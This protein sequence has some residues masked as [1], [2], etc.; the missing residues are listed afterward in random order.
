[1]QAV[2]P[3]SKTG[4][5]PFEK[6]LRIVRENAVLLGTERAPLAACVGR[7]LREDAASDMAMP[8]FDKSAMDG[9]ACRRPDLPGPLEV[10]ETIPAGQRPSR[11]VGKGQ[12][13]KIMTGAM[14]PKGADCVI[15]V[16][17]TET[18]PDGRVRRR[19]R[20]GADHGRDA[21]DNICR[22]GEDVSPGQKLVLAGPAS[23]RSCPRGIGRPC[24]A[25]RE[26]AARGRGPA[27]GDGRIPAPGPKARRSATHSLQ[28]LPRLSVRLRPGLWDRAR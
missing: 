1:M 17:E 27:T 5:I 8:P 15:V 6:A 7:V 3:D 23:V 16:E 26:Q 12:C 11:K 18:L 13:S 24:E 9:F 20:D 28:A 21:A 4:L 22:K 14:L 19:S 2:L 10:L 25:P